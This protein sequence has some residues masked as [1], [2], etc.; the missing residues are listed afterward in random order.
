[1]KIVITGAAGFLGWHLRCRF[2]ALH[3]EHEVIAVDRAGFGRL[4]DLCAGADA[5]I[6]V[7]GINRGED[8]EVHDGNVDLARAVARAIENSSVRRLVY[9][10]SIQS[11]NGTPY[12][13]G[14]QQAARILAA[15]GVETVDVVLPNL[16]GEHGRPA[17]NSFVATFVRDVVHG[18]TPTVNDSRVEL[19]HVQRAAAALIDALDTPESQL[20]P[21]G[22]LR[23]VAEVLGLL[24][25]FDHCYRD[26]EIPPLDAAF[27]T[28]LFNTY[29]AAAFEARGPIPLVRRSDARGHLV[30]SVK[31][32][33]GAGQTFFSTTVPGVT[34]G[35]HFHLGKIERFVVIRGQGRIRLRRMFTDRVFAFDVD[36]EVPVAID[37]PTMWTHNI[38]NI[39]DDEL[40]TLFW[41]DSVFDPENPDTY[42]ELVEA[43]S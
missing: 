9:A 26:G 31:A 8:G 25:G 34:R 20:R 24:Q 35:D 40:F 15:S 14:K 27:T 41:T 21:E 28:E 10:N 39:G 6:H 11:G 7:A 3:R 29:R 13:D 36:G 1:M 37:M 12:G 30:E 23:G 16:F 43:S 19:L 4:A 32:H 22:E 33:G 17:Y 42:P 2:A 38:T 5:V 18:R